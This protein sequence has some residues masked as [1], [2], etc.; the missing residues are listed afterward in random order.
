M[1]ATGFVPHVLIPNERTRRATNGIVTSDSFQD[2][3]LQ[4]LLQ[5][6]QVQGDYA[7]KTIESVWDHPEYLVQNVGETL[8]P[9]QSLSSTT[10]PLPPLQNCQDFA[11]PAPPCVKP[12]QLPPPM[13][14]PCLSSPS[15]PG[16]PTA[17]N[18]TAT[19]TMRPTKRKAVSPRP[20]RT[21]AGKYPLVL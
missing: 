15:P 12:P 6:S 20:S 5:Q 19:A 9:L 7:V 16:T 8:I 13:L 21:K 10:K 3:S 18:Y 1:F 11:H 14:L 4:Q 2:Y 17:R